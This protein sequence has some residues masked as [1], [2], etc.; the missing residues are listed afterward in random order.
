MWGSSFHGTS[1]AA[2]RQGSSV[3]A[4]R[5]GAAGRLGGDPFGGTQ[6]GAP[7]AWV[8]G[9]LGGRGDE[10]LRDQQA[11]ARL[12]PAYADRRLGRAGAAPAL[13]LQEALDDSV[14]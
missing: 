13:G 8:G 12:A 5:G 11:Q 10:A 4:G 3:P 2:D 9:D 6:P 7:G 14:L 1:A